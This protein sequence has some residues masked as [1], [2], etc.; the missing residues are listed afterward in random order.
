M[1]GPSLVQENINEFVQNQGYGVKGLVDIM[2]IKTLPTQYIHPIEERFNINTNKLKHNN[3]IPIIDMSSPNTELLEK[4]VCEAAEKWGFFQIVNHGVPLEVLEEVKAATYRFFEQPVEEKS[5]YMKGKL[6]K[7]VTYGSSFAPEMEKALEWKDKLRL[8]F[9]SQEEANSLWPTACRNEALKFLNST[10]HITQR[11]MEI[12]MRGLGINEIDK[13]KTSL[14]MGAKTINF[15]F[16]P[17][18]PNPDLTFGVSRHSDISTLTILLQEDISGLYARSLDG[19]SW[20]DIPPVKGA[21]VINVGDALQILS[22]GKYQSVEHW[23]VANEHKDRVSVPIFVTPT[24]RDII[25]PF[26]ELLERGETPLY[27]QVL[28]SDYIKNF[29]NNAL[30]GKATIDFAKV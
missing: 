27:K 29:L 21:L 20:T 30:D 24:P 15:N 13:R 18:C 9:V 23:A 26:E 19:E 25:G 6:S 22:N 5:K 4:S 17:K 2:K 8:S 14:L 10:Q 28:F 1:L 16:Y 3:C 7:N 12:L 11:L